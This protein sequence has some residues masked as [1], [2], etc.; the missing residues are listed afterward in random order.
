MLGGDSQPEVCLRGPRRANTLGGLWVAQA[1]PLGAARAPTRPAP[2]VARALAHRKHSETVTSL[3]LLALAV[4]DGPVNRLSGQGTKGL[5]SGSSVPGHKTVSPDSALMPASHTPSP[6]ARTKAH[7]LRTGC[8]LASDGPR[9]HAATSPKAWARP[10]WLRAHIPGSGD[11]ELIRASGRS[12]EEL[13]VRGHWSPGRKAGRKDSAG[14]ETAP[15][16]LPHITRAGS[17]SGHG[18]LNSRPPVR[19]RVLPNLASVN[20]LSSSSL[21]PRVFPY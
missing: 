5:Q 10:T 2:A 14:E 19:V 6:Q 7:S 15:L 20:M 9:G 11:Q 13:G 4:P 1:L 21:P 16:L 18:I 17:S 8:P 12:R 3:L